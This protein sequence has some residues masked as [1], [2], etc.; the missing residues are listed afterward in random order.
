MTSN[1]IFII[2]S[3]ISGQ[4]LSFIWSFVVVHGFLLKQFFGVDFTY[5]F[6]NFSLVFVSFLFLHLFFV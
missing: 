5:L 1:L 6:A 2:L 4:R 3:Y